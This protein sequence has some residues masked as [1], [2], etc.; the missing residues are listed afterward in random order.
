MRAKPPFTAKRNEATLSGADPSEA[1]LERT[2]LGDTP[3]TGLGSGMP[4]AQSICSGRA[5]VVGTLNLVS[6]RSPSQVV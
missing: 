5:P 4:P 3:E 2:D 1:Y 6:S